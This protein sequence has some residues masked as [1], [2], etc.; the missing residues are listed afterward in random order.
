MPLELSR[1]HRA[2]A[3]SSLRRHSA[4]NAVDG[5]PATKWISAPF[6]IR[7]SWRV[8][9]GRIRELTGLTVEFGSRPRHLTYRVETSIDGRDWATVASRTPE[10]KVQRTEFTGLGRYVRIVATRH[11][12]PVQLAGVQVMGSR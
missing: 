11:A 3:S 7:P 2:K 12:G 5:D 1:G 4:A 6:D 10:E 9:L 8:D